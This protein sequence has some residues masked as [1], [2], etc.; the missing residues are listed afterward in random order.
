MYYYREC[1]KLRGFEVICQKLHRPRDKEGRIESSIELSTLAYG[2][3][4]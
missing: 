3:C 1:S 4:V 2:N